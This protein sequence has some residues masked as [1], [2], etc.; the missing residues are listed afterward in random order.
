MPAARCLR[1]DSRAFMRARRDTAWA[2][3]DSVP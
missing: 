1:K 2:A 3:D